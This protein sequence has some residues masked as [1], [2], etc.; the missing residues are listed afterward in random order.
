MQSRRAEGHSKSMRRQNARFSNG[1]GW[2]QLS[3]R[4]SGRTAMPK[5]L[6]L[7]SGSGVAS[8]QSVLS[9]QVCDL[10][11]LR[12]LYYR[13]T[14]L[15]K[16]KSDYQWHRVLSLLFG[17]WWCST[18]EGVRQRNTND[19]WARVLELEVKFIGRLGQF[20]LCS[21]PTDLSRCSSESVFVLFRDAPTPGASV[22]KINSLAFSNFVCKILDSNINTYEIY[23]YMKYELLLI[24]ILRKPTGCLS[25]VLLFIVYNYCLWCHQ[26]IPQIETS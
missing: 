14:Y 12:G 22:R 3:Q 7:F 19:I 17:L 1:P 20:E 15:N 5:S 13:Q 21:G 9:A 24:I 10:V 4:V 2:D 6:W 8:F 26:V 11:L 18:N 23:I 16:I 25:H